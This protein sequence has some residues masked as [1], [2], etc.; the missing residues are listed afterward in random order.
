MAVW[1]ELRR[2]GVRGVSII[3]E[4]VW[5][6]TALHRASGE[7]R[8]REAHGR[9]GGPVAPLAPALA[10]EPRFRGMSREPTATEP[11]LHVDIDAFYASVEVLKDPSLAGK[12]VVVGRTG[13]RG[14]VMSASY[15]ARALRRSHRRCRR[16][17]ARR[18]CPAGGLPAAGL[19]CL[20]RLLE[21]LPG[22]PAARYRRSWSRS[23]W[24]RRSSTSRAPTMLFGSPAE[25]AREDPR[26]RGPRGRR[27]VLRRRRP[28]EVRREA[29]LR[30]GKPD[31]L[32][33]VPADGVQAFLDP[34]PVGALWGV[35]RRPARPS[36]V[37]GS[38]RSASW[39]ARRPRSWSDCWERE[40]PATSGSSRTA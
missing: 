4:E 36:A 29:R 2:T 8:L 38:A 7:G 13:P 32:L 35:G 25:I 15:E 16:V 23:P 26:R 18:L 5:D 20:P 6:L 11:I 34:L 24:T 9:R 10:C 33:V 27:H 17:R 14:V 21:P 40:R 31:G 3:A 39:D 28:D 12:P 19:R 37:W 30:W 22:G 1:G